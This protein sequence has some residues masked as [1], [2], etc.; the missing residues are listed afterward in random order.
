MYFTPKEN[1]YG[2]I[3][4]GY[5]SLQQMYENEITAVIQSVGKKYS[6]DELKKRHIEY[7]FCDENYV[8][9]IITLSLTRH[10]RICVISKNAI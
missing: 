10:D 3:Y 8:N 5:M 7:F 4:N 6:P 2:Y 1:Q 9:D